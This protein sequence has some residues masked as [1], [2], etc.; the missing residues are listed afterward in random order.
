MPLD[1]F[2]SEAMQGLAGGAD[3]VPVADAKFLHASAGTS[4]AFRTTFSR[5]NP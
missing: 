4:D 2:I 5:M 1:Q 3:E